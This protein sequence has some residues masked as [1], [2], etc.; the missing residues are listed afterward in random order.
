MFGRNIYHNVTDNGVKQMATV[1]C[2]TESANSMALFNSVETVRFW[3][4]QLILLIQSPS[5]REPVPVGIA[6]CY[7]QITCCIQL[8]V[9]SWHTVVLQCGVFFTIGYSSQAIS[10]GNKRNER[11]NTFQI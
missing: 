7:L 11:L 3:I 1:S 6:S 5:V 8:E 10:E 2:L 4:I 9:R